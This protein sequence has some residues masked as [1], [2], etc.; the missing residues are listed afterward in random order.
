MILSG[1]ALADEI[2]EEIKHQIASYSSSPGLA[3]VLMGDHAPSLAYVSMKTKACQAVGIQTFLHRLPPSTSEVYLIQLI[4]E[5]NNDPSVDGILVQLPLP[6]HINPEKIVATIDPNKDV[7]GF[8]PINLGKLLLG[9][10]SGFVPCTPLGVKVLLERSHIS[11]EGKDLVIV[12]RSSI[13][14]KPL[15]ALLMQNAPA[16]NATVTVVHSRTKDLIQHTARADILVAALGSP[17][18]I[19]EEMVKEGAVVI[20]VGINREEDPQSPKGFRLVG[21]VDFDAVAPKCQAITPVPKGVGPMT[22]A[23][24]LHNTLL[25]YQR[26]HA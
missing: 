23:M 7:D 15:A 20:D 5:L 26:K 22:V 24:L 12:G 16:C 17:R 8:H 9:I 18:F 6:S 21:D 3:V 25:S 10:S 2:Q 19:K 4:Q 14:G 13:V 11:T 1:R